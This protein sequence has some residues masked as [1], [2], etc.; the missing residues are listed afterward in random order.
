MPL[1]EA[2]IPIKNGFLPVETIG[3]PSSF[4]KHIVFVDSVCQSKNISLTSQGPSVL[5]RATQTNEK[6]IFL[7][8]RVEHSEFLITFILMLIKPVE[9]PAD[10]G[11][12]IAQLRCDIIKCYAYSLSFQIQKSPRIRH[13]KTPFCPCRTSWA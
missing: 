3:D 7:F 9:S 6:C 8:A 10:K 13:Q 2:K 5:A 4:Y 1:R 11:L 12:T